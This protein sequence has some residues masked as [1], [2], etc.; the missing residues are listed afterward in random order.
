M[1]IFYLSLDECIWNS[2][3]CHNFLF[4]FPF[5][6]LPYFQMNLENIQLFA[7]ILEV[8]GIV[9]TNS[10]VRLGLYHLYHSL[11]LPLD[12]YESKESVWVSCSWTVLE[13]QCVVLLF[14]MHQIVGVQSINHPRREWGGLG[15]G[16]LFATAIYKSCLTW[17]STL[18]WQVHLKL[19]YK[20][21]LLL[22]HSLLSLKAST[23]SSQL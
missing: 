1:S 12:R 6:I 23:D 7:Y 22:E 16:D 14:L 11:N 15:Y 9:S 10:L 2:I 20:A 18:F 4:Y 3:W 19:F 17:S 5:H 8:L 21:A 13:L